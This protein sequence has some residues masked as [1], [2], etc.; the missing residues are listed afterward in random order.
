MSVQSHSLHAS[1]MRIPS[2]GVIIVFCIVHVVW[3]GIMPLRTD[4]SSSFKTTQAQVESAIIASSLM[5]AASMFN[6]IVVVDILFSIWLSHHISSSCLSA[7]LDLIDSSDHLQ[8]HIGTIMA[9]PSS[10]CLILFS[11]GVYS[12]N[13]GKSKVTSF[14]QI[15]LLVVS[16]QLS[17]VSRWIL[18]PKTRKYADQGREQFQIADCCTIGLLIRLVDPLRLEVTPFIPNVVS[19]FVHKCSCTCS[20][21]SSCLSPFQLR[22]S[23]SAVTCFTTTTTSSPL[24]CLLFQEGRE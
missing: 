6:V 16:C 20:W 21:V 12:T 23:E 22:R 5:V 24:T 17:V 10:I 19:L 18:Q 3:C 1:W 13:L 11:F 8:R 15:Q 14:S 4:R 7:R 2:V 9:E